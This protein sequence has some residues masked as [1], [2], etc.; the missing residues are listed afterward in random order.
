MDIEAFKDAC[1]YRDNGWRP[2]TYLSTHNA[3]VADNRRGFSGNEDSEPPLGWPRLAAMHDQFNNLCVFRDFSWV[4][5]QLTLYKGR[6]LAFLSNRLRQFDRDRTEHL[7]GLTEYQKRLPGQTVAP[8]DY[9][10]LMEEIERGYN[11]YWPL[12]E[13]RQQLHRLHPVPR[14]QWED[15]LRHAVERGML[16]RDAYAWMDSPDEFVSPSPP[17]PAWVVRFVYS[18]VGKW[19]IASHLLPLTPPFFFS[20]S[21]LHPT[22]QPTHK[23]TPVLQINLYP[24]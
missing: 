6:R 22:H 14:E 13:R 20:P 10:V 18:R 1:H 7:R 21:T 24:L 9:D 23:S 3:D 15:L 17:P 8:S 5:W 4:L 2:T 16:D 19:I 11:E 12:C